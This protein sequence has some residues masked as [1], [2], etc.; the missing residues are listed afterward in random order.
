MLN[1]RSQ[2][3]G[4]FER[5]GIAKCGSKLRRSFTY[6]IGFGDAGEEFRQSADTTSLGH[7]TGD[8]VDVVHKG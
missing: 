2:S 8:P 4:N 3:V 1:S 5:H 6:Q 7:A